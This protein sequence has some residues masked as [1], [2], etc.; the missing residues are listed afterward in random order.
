MAAKARTVR[1]V[2]NEPSGA[3]TIADCRYR[4]I[5][6]LHCVLC[7][8]RGLWSGNGPQAGPG[9]LLCGECGA[10]FDFLNGPERDVTEPETAALMRAVK[11]RRGVRRKLDGEILTSPAAAAEL[12]P[13][14]T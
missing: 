4:L 9:Y 5:D 6:D 3:V 13:L 12:M 2:L 11:Q 7:G 8:H 10:G 14:L 1:I